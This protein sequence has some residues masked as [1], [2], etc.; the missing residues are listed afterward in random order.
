MIISV[1]EP[2][3]RGELELPVSKSLVQ[4]HWM[5]RALHQIPTSYEIGSQIDDLRTLSHIL[6]HPEASQWDCQDSGACARFALALAV[7]QQH[8]LR[9]TGGRRLCERPIGP[10]VEALKSLG[11]TIT[12]EGQS[13]YLPVKVEPSS[14]TGGRIKIDASESSQFV[15]SLM[16]LG[17]LL[18]GGLE[19]ELEKAPASWPYIQ[20]TAGVMQAYHLTVEFSDDASDA[21]LLINVRPGTAVDIG[22][23]FMEG[24]WSA[25]AFWYAAAALS[26]EADILLTNLDPFSVQGDAVLPDIY[27]VL[28]VSTEFLENG[29]RLR[30]AGP[31]ETHQLELDLTDTPDL[32][33]ALAVTA[34]GLGLEAELRGIARLAHKESNRPAAL[35]VELAKIGVN[36]KVEGDIAHLP[37]HEP[38]PSGSV[39]FESH[40]DHRVA[41][42][43][44]PLALRL[45]KVSI[46]QPEVVSKS[47]PQ[48]WQHMKKCLILGTVSQES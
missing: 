22:L 11:A 26:G 36:L 7:Q 39:T 18:P 44:A 2:V 4:R 37:A 30:K 14:L 27:D 1:T 28:G 29:V 12:Y 10:L 40:G 21:P 47:Y 33:P 15:S 46:L 23:P 45:R 38:S 32:F 25:A 20:M 42:A 24:D 19:I 3:L 31:P 41:M 13:G 16:M 6:L 34:A 17:S 35:K 5:I 43:L 8:T 9:I 48:F